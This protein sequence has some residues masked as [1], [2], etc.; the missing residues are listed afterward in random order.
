M[1]CDLMLMTW[2]A[3]FCFLN[4]QN[5]DKVQ[6]FSILDMHKQHKC[7]MLIEVQMLLIC[8]C[9]SLLSYNNIIIISLYSYYVQYI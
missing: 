8:A 3:C 4:S 9:E 6:D 5:I 2:Y 1:T 7:V